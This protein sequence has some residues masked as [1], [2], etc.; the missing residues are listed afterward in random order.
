[1]LGNQI[2]NIGPSGCN[3]IHGIYV[4]NPYD[5]VENNIVGGIGGGQCITSY[6]QATNLVISNNTV[7]NCGHIGILLGNNSGSLNDTT[8]VNNIIR[9]AQGIAFSCY[10]GLGS[11]INVTNNDAY[12][13]SGSYSNVFG[14]SQS[15]HCTFS[16]NITSDPEFVNYQSNGTGN[17]Q[18]SAGSAAIDAGSTACAIGVT[19]CVPALDIEGGTRLA[20]GAWDIGAYQFGAAPG[21]WPWY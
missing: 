9:D 3:V 13:S 7:F 6:H 8:A 11:N 4:S 15:S 21:S 2:Y 10:T 12:A 16:S 18:L 5:I 14:G 20:G 1:M 19:S 17:Y